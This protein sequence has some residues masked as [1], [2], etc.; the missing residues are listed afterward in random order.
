TDAEGSYDVLVPPDG[1]RGRSSVQVG[2]LAQ[3][4]LPYS[5]DRLRNRFPAAGGEQEMPSFVVKRGTNLTGT[6]VDADARPVP[7]AHVQAAAV[8]AG[9]KHSRRVLVETDAQGSFSVGPMDP[10]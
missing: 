8:D 5:V 3:P 7:L 2:P 6:V 10:D 4:W 9:R 1:D